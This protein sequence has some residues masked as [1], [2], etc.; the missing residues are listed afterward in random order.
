L[1]KQARETL[2]FF[3]ERSMPILVGAQKIRMPTGV[4]TV[5]A[6]FTWFQVEMGTLLGV[7]LENI[8]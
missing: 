2:E 1:E 7:E 3:K 6:K 4:Q 8:A 5:K